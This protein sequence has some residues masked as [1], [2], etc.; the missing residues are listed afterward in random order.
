MK[1]WEYRLLNPKDAEGGSLF[2]GKSRDA[3]EEYLNKLGEQGWEIVNL[4]FR[5]FEEKTSFAGVAKREKR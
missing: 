2:W 4:D 1:K 3:V 5:E